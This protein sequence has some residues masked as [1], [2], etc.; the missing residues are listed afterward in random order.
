HR[1]EREEEGWLSQPQQLRAMPTA[2]TRPNQN[3]EH[4][5]LEDVRGA[6]GRSEHDSPTTDDGTQSRHRKQTGR[7]LK[8]RQPKHA[9]GQQ[10]EGKGNGGELPGYE[11]GR[12]GHDPKKAERS[13]DG[14]PHG[15]TTGAPAVTTA[16]FRRSGS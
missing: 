1:H 3:R 9:D 13:E 10:L 7:W 16:E 6:K 2:N 8:Q 11:Q 5:L 12:S 15:T 4:Q 14:L